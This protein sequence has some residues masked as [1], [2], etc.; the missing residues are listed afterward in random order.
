MKPQSATDGIGCVV[1]ILARSRSV[2]FITGAGISADSGLPTYRG[3]GGL[4][5]VEHPEEGFPIEEILSGKMLRYRP[6]LT[7]KY[8]SQIEQAT[9]LTVSV[10]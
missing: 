10:F 9:S 4:Y 2:L 3:I 1:D 8:L 5:N 7:W 6:D